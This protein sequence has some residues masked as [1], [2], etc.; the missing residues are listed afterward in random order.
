MIKNLPDLL[1]YHVQNLYA[2]ET[3]L[4]KEFPGIIEKAQHRSLKNALT[5]HLNITKE[6]KERL[7]KIV[8]ILNDYKGEVQVQLKPD[9]VCKGIAAL[10]QETYD[11]FD[12]GLEK[13]V[14]DA[15]IISS[16]QKIE[17]Y[18]ISSYGTALAYAKQ[19]K[20][21]ELEELLEETLNEEYEADDLLTALATAS[22]NKEA[23]TADVK[24]EDKTN[25]ETDVSEDDMGSAG[26]IHITERTITSPG[27]RAGT[28][29]RRY[30]T[31][32][33]RGH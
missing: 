25:L 27:G 10:L 17:H 12:E 29:H 9:H 18:E 23:V 24:V 22:L 11:L 20:V 5:H 3:L 28:S 30:G 26:Q 13:E 21:A 15:A 1:H 14:I 6:Q 7:E 31:G 16:V 4:L 8:D 32:E 19:L 33:S 2:A